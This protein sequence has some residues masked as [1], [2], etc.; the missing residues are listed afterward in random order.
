[1]HEDVDPEEESVHAVLDQVSAELFSV[2]SS[3]SHEVISHL[4]GMLPGDAQVY[5]EQQRVL[6][7]S[8]ADVIVTGMLDCLRMESAEV[9]CS[10]LQSMCMLCEHIPMHLESRLLSV[11]GYATTSTKLSPAKDRTSFR[12][13]DYC[14]VSSCSP[15]R[16][17]SPLTSADQPPIKRPCI[18][19]W[20]QY[21]S[22]VRK[23][24][25]RRWENLSGHLLKEVQLEDIW[26]S[27]R[28]M[29]RVRDRPNQTPASDRGN[30]TPD[31]SEDYGSM[32][33]R[34][35][36]DTFL[37]GCVKAVTV[38][39]GQPGSGKT[40]LMSCLGQQWAHGLGPIPSSYLFV[41]LEFRQLNLLS[42]PV[43]LF[44]LLFQHYLPPQGGNSEKR[45]IFDHL[46][47][48]PE[49]SCW[50]LDGYDEF[51][52]EIFGKDAQSEEVSDPQNNMPVANLISALLNRHILPGCTVVVTCRAQDVIDFEGV[53]DKVGH[54]L[55][56][57]HCEIKDYVTNFFGRNADKGVGTQAADLLFSNRHLLAMSTI[58]A[59][60]HICCIC[61]EHLL[62]DGRQ[63]ASTTQSGDRGRNPKKNIQNL[64]SA[65][66]D[67][68]SCDE[69]GGE[70]TEDNTSAENLRGEEASPHGLPQIPTTLTQVYFTLLEVFLRRDTP[71]ITT[72]PERIGF[73]LSQYGSEVCELSQLAWRGVEK[74]KILFMKEDIPQELLEFSTRTGLFSQVEVR[75]EDGMLVSAYCF[76]HLTLQEFLAALRLMTSDD[77]PDTQLKNKFSLRTRWMTRS[78]QRTV[79]T[80]SLYRYVCGLASSGCTAVLVQLVGTG[81]QTWVQKRQALILKLL[82][83]LSV[84]NTLTG[85][86][87]LELC[88]CVQESQDDQIAKEVVGTRPN[89][90]LRNIQLLPNDVEALAFVVNSVGD[91]GIGL[92]FRACSMELECLTFLPRCQ[93]IHRLSFRSRKYDDHFAEQLSSILPEF[94]NL[95]KLEL[96][97]ASLTEKGAASLSSALQKCPHISEIN[98]S[99]NNLKDSG[100]RFIAD[101][102]PKLQ[103]LVS[104]SL[105]RNNGSLRG[106]GYLIQMMTSCLNIQHVHVNGLEDVTVTFSQNCGTKSL[107]ST[108]EPTIS[109]LNQSWNKTATQGL[110]ESLACCPVLSV[111]DLSGGEWDVQSLK[112]LTQFLPQTRIFRKIILSNSSL[113]SKGLKMLLEVLPHLSNIQEIDASNNG[114][115][116]AGVTM[117]A[118]A[119]SSH[120]NLQQVHISNG[121]KQQ[122]ILKFCWN[123]SDDN[124][125]LK[126]F[127]MIK[128]RLLPSYMTSLCQKLIRCCFHFELAFSHCSMTD[129]AVK[130]LLKFLPKM[131]SLH[132]LNVSH[133]ITSTDMALRALCSLNQ[134][135]RVTS[136]ELR[137]C[138]ESFVQF[139]RV[140]AEQTRCRLTDFDLNDANMQQLL[141]ILQQVP[142]LSELD[143]SGNHLKD[144]AVNRVVDFLPMLKIASYVNLSNNMMTQQG[145]LDVA[146]TLCTCHSVS[147]VE[148]SLGEEKRS[149][150][151]FREYRGEKSLSVTDSSLSLEHLGRIAEIMSNCPSLTKLE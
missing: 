106:V 63:E 57:E 116:I 49:Q 90:E 102:F 26:I 19:L 126:E 24:M 121:G 62:M 30:R 115:G 87:L 85:P 20:E 35:T 137:H 84:S 122:V 25:V 53:S 4:C 40:L 23:F 15:E 44:E 104:A 82:K 96:S 11:A 27:P 17:K 150:I 108:S 50:V 68:E 124:K 13:T 142:Q 99:D 69:K 117:L 75:R 39:V 114:I 61:M 58:P 127:R 113:G 54:L 37:Q 3:Q 112:T 148:V 1:M 128:S 98:L 21:M 14:E 144:E 132:R 70:G 8:S 139:D 100:I 109:L 120:G 118:S 149:L 33:S 12:N 6:G 31:T 146:G 29:S 97:C 45:A 2:L 34:V 83:K 73:T 125:L 51:H 80:D 135:Q 94:A 151:W 65:G 123:N 101:L 28:S 48:N 42:R 74:N 78:D 10:F 105:G 93:Y 36:L 143:L 141:E 9:C 134:S 7:S 18:D 88:H 55:G 64:H 47:S 67:A 60:C 22:A 110:T 145:V 76:I 59:L 136:V 147:S 138:D 103:Q 129:E 71:K 133:S 111:L 131:T 89:V 119:L 5:M 41:L 77:V 92:N 43:S 86:K 16:Q 38:M 130:N 32:E 72:P 107:E 140:K 56:W 52:S 66:G 81:R 91:K 79:F 95:R 46:I